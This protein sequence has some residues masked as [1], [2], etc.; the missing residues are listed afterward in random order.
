MNVNSP[1]PKTLYWTEKISSIWIIFGLALMVGVGSFVGGVY[2]ELARF[3]AV[4]ALLLQI[5][6][7]LRGRQKRFLTSPLFLLSV[8]GTTFFSVVQ[9]IWV[10]DLPWSTWNFALS[11]FVGSQA[12]AVILT[13]CMAALVMYSL[14]SRDLNSNKPY[15]I[16]PDKWLHQNNYEII[17]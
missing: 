5:T 13:F 11:V 15:E 10:N 4:C 14:S 1:I 17:S 6:L 12:E 7:E 16:E 8:I 2:V 3:S 9:G